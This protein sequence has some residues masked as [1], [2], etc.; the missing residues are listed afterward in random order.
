MP[1]LAPKCL[2]CAT[3]RPINRRQLCA[4]CT[5]R[6]AGLYPH[7]GQLYIHVVKDPE[8]EQRIEEYAAAVAAGRPIPWRRRRGE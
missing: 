4:R 7:Q 8:A 1:E 6:Y 3:R 2:H 5:A